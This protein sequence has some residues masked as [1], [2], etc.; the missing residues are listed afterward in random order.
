M[1]NRVPTRTI[2]QAIDVVTAAISY[3]HAYSTLRKDCWSA[4]GGLV[5]FALKALALLWTEAG[6]GP[7][8][9]VGLVLPVVAAVVVVGGVTVGGVLN[10]MLGAGGWVA[11]PVVV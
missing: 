5:T 9:D 2:S 1:A 4:T 7:T 6:A 3:R 8:V 11:A 10:G